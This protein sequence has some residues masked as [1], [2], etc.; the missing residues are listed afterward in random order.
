M[1][2]R[3]ISEIYKILMSRGWLE[4]PPFL[5]KWEEELGVNCS[6]ET[7]KNI[8][9]ATHGTASD[10]KTIE[11]NYKCLARWYMTPV[12]FSKFAT[13]RSPNCWRGCGTPGNMAH[14]W[15]NCPK[16]KLFWKGVI[17]IIEEITGKVI[18]YNP[19][20]CLFHGSEGGKKR[21]KSSLMPV[22][23]NSAKNVIPK[24]WQEVE[25]PKI[26]DW[27]TRVNETFLLEKAEVEVQADR[28]QED[29]RG[30]W[31]SWVAFRKSK[32][33]VEVMIL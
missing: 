3:K 8:L 19:W 29:E 30:K 10:M 1:V 4:P 20:D 16:I 2:K 25:A 7:A 14:L 26:R 17:G 12:K 15:W 18:K 31:G 33:Y 13:D 9:G 32:R 11:S 22:P 27:I 24:K 23:L 6:S 21:Y 28:D 5:K